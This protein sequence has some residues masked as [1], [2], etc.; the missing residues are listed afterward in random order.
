MP[1]S[2]TGNIKGAT[3]ATGSTGATGPTGVAP[4]G[5]VVMFGS[6]TPPAGWVVCDGSS[7]L[8]TGTFAA[9]FAVIGTSFGSVDGTHFN[10]PNMTSNNFPLGSTSPGVAGGAATHTH[11]SAAHSHPLSAAGQALVQAA[12]TLIS[13]LRINTT[14]GWTDNI[15]YTGSGGATTATAQTRGAQLAGTTDST[16][17]GVSGS[18]STYPPYVTFM[19]IIKL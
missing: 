12:G 15:E 18:T 14:V 11:T 6:V 7:Q 17:P 19:F 3:G 5:S 10:L 16:T 1:W 13:F 2:T 9:L 4:T 8:R